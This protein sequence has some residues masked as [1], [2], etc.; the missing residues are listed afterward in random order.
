MSVY[1]GEIF[2]LAMPEGFARGAKRYGLLLEGMRMVYLN[3]FLYLQIIPVGAP[4]DAKGPPPKWLFK[5]LLKLHPELRKRVRRCKEVLAER[6]WR[7]EV[8]EW[9]ST[10]RRQM[11]SAN[12]A[13]QAVELSAL[14]NS[15]LYAHLTECRDNLYQALVTHHTLTASNGVPL[16]RYLSRVTGWTGLPE[17][18]VL[19]LLRGVSPSSV[20][21]TEELARLH[22]ALADHGEAVSWLASVAAGTGD[23]AAEVL[24]RLLDVGGEL[25]AAMRSYIEVTGNRLGTGYDVADRRVVEVPDVLLRGLAVRLKRDN[26]VV[27]LSAQVDA[28]RA[29]VPV[30]YQAEFDDLLV[31]AR[32]THDIRDERIVLGDSWATGLTRRALLEA[33]DR[34]AKQGLIDE[35]EQLVDATHEEIGGLLTAEPAVSRQQLAQRH[36]GRCN[37]KIED[38]PTFLGSE[39]GPPPPDDWL[40]PAVREVMGGMGAFLN[41]NF[42]DSAAQSLERANEQADSSTLT[43]LGCSGGIYEGPA[44]VIAIPAEMDQ[45]QQ[46]EVLVVASTSPAFNVVLPLLGAI[47]TERGGMLSHVA[48]VAREYDIPAVASVPRALTKIVTGQQ[49]RVDGSS[50]TVELLT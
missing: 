20:G 3:H 19:D 35:P 7:L 10:I 22:Q 6:T 47:V 18:Q 31:D 33:G 4:T 49:L 25:G 32:L 28:V 16:G 17:H 39:P 2:P 38:M 13:L 24:Q 5:L 23:A 11:V 42:G 27:D 9:N 1:M 29:R 8:D 43:G 36:Q 50:G 14:D 34:L 45:I 40:P 44:R 15:E 37:A 26:S 30:E 48:V 41:G 21:L 12:L 46:G